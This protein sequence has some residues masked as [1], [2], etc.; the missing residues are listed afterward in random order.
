MQL[1]PCGGKPVSRY[2]EHAEKQIHSIDENIVIQMVQ[3]SKG[4]TYISEFKVSYGWVGHF[5][6]QTLP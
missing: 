3:V 6:A 2:Y 4:T 1:S 5:M